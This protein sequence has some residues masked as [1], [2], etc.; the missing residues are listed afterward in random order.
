MNA[1]ARAAI[2]AAASVAGVTTIT[3]YYRQSTAAGQGWVNLARID[4][5]NPFG[6]VAT[7]HVVIPLPADLAVSEQWLDAHAE[8]IRAA[9]ASE[10]AVRNLTPTNL[11]MPAGATVP[12]LLIEGQRES[13]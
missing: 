3:P 12:A 7:W 2:A 8:T 11:V 4:Y 6:G 13:E 5:P 10:M 9:V 1:D